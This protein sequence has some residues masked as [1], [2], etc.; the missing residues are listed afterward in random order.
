MSKKEI[1]STKLV[2][3]FCLNVIIGNLPSKLAFI[4]YYSKL[5]TNSY[6]LFVT[7]SNIMLFISHG[8]I[9]FINILFNDQFYDK[10]LMLFKLHK[11]IRSVAGSNEHV[12]S[13]TVT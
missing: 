1:K 2:I 7:M 13:Q 10:F 4:A 5:N 11:Q 6:N 9:F 8:N 12:G 3:V